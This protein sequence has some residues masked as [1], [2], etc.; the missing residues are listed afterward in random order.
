MTARPFQALRDRMTPERRARNARRTEALIEQFREAPSD[1]YGRQVERWR[2][3]ANVGTRAWDEIWREQ[4]NA[5][6]IVAGAYQADLLDDLR[7]A[8]DRAI[9]GGEGIGSFRARFGEIVN[10]YGWSYHGSFAWRSRLIFEQNIRTSYS[11]GR[12]AQLTDPN[13]L[14]ARPF[15]RYN[16]SERVEHP[17]PEHV[18]WDGLVLEAS[19][20]WWETHFPPG[21]FGCQ[22]SVTAL[23]RRQ[24]AK[25]GR[26]GPDTPP[27][28]GFW[29]TRRPSTGEDIVTPAGIDPGFDYIPGKT[30]PAIPSGGSTGATARRR[31]RAPQVEHAAKLA[32]RKLEPADKLRVG[33]KVNA[34]TDGSAIDALFVDSPQLRAVQAWLDELQPTVI[35]ARDRAAM[36]REIRRDRDG[37]WTDL[38]RYIFNEQ[39]PSEGQAWGWTHN[40]L[41]QGATVTHAPASGLAALAADRIERR[42]VMTDMRAGVRESML[43]RDEGGDPFNAFYATP[44]RV[45]LSGASDDVLNA[46]Y[47]VIHELGHQVHYKILQ[48]DAPRPVGISAHKRRAMTRYAKTNNAEWHAEH[49]V[50]WAF[51]RQGLLDRQPLIAEYFDWVFRDYL[52]KRYPKPKTW[53]PPKT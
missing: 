38:D 53:K 5:A 28:D 41:T 32:A 50:M 24:L 3:K 26:F 36:Q 4:H 34:G 42:R 19:D 45:R 40:A 29:T 39:A 11:A 2:K 37:G 21:G 51:D 27:D 22:C 18:A 49:F 44:K 46:I 33:R 23:S 7:E 48:S 13:M 43:R 47:T 14:R 15:W 16:H 6:F 1:Y 8:V 52:G 10:R 12:Y 20:T 30:V 25:M 31:P 17:R 35:T 9:V